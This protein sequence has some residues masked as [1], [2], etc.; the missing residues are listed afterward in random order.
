MAGIHQTGQGSLTEQAARNLEKILTDHQKAD[1]LLLARVIQADA[2][3]VQG[4]K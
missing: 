1:I 2:P 4:G 3:I